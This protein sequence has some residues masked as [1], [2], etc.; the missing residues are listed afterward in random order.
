MRGNVDPVAL[1]AGEDFITDKIHDTIKKAGTRNHIMAGLGWWLPY[2]GSRNP[3]ESAR[4][5]PS[6]ESVR[7][8]K[9]HPSDGVGWGGVGWGGVGWGGVGCGRRRT[10]GITRR[11][12][13]PLNACY[14]VMS[15]RA[16]DNAHKVDSSLLACPDCMM[17]M[18]DVHRSYHVLPH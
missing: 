18:C 2:L 3:P 6:T 8:Q 16:T 7:I 4:I 9:Y 10:T 5:R 12:R 1:F 15:P 17:P 11:R 14:L 13:V